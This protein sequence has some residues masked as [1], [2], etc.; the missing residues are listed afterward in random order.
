MNLRIVM[1]CAALL[2]LAASCGCGCGSAK[3]GSG[4][5]CEKNEDC[6]AGLWCLGGI[7]QN[8]PDA[9]SPT[10]GDGSQEDDAGNPVEDAGHPDAGYDAG[11]D[12]GHDAGADIGHDAATDTGADAAEYDAAEDAG[13][14]GGATDGGLDGGPDGASDAG[15]DGGED[16][17]GGSTDACVYGTIS[18]TADPNH[19][20]ADGTHTITLDA[21]PLLCDGNRMPEMTMVTF[22]TTNGAFVASG[23]K[24][25][26]FPTTGGHA[27]A[28]LASSMA[29]MTSVTAQVTG[30]DGAVV[31]TDLSVQF[32]A[33]P[34]RCRYPPTTRH[35]SPSPPWR[36]TA[37]S[38][39]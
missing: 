33:A 25:T 36:S 17:D 31:S 27:L 5:V 38:R 30:H 14:D 29:G 23:T 26:S 16:A 34:R 10:T 37:T 19:A 15:G 7:C 18:M 11:H 32:T 1:G 28:V 22:Y 2:A 8:A 12:A 6:A 24:T 20:P 35:R 4:Q 9:G 13:T 39:P 3:S 21:A